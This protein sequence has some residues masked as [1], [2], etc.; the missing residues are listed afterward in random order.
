MLKKKQDV[1]PMFLKH[2]NKY[3]YSIIILQVAD[4]T[5]KPG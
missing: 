1:Y 2:A 4:V 3:P 5:N